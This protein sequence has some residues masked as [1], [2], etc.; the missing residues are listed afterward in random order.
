M[1]ETFAFNADIQQLMS[2]SAGSNDVGCRSVM[3]HLENISLSPRMDRC[4]LLGF[5]S[6][7]RV[8][9]QKHDARK[10]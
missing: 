7:I 3:Y 4:F 10:V 9:N 1:A 6:P 8:S 5:R 2:F